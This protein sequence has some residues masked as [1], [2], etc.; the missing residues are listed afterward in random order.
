MDRNLRAFDLETGREIVE[1]SLLRVA[2][3]LP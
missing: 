3:P 1:A 2:R